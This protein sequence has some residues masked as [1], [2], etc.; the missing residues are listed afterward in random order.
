VGLG[1]ADRWGYQPF[2]LPRQ[3]R[4][5]GDQAGAA[6]NWRPELYAVPRAEIGAALERRVSALQDDYPGVGPEKR[7]R[8]WRVIIP[9]DLRLGHDAHFIQSTRQFLHYLE[10]PPTRSQS[11]RAN[12]LAKYYVCTAGVA[13]ARH[14]G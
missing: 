8:E 9:D 5:V 7:S 14:A 6:E 13:L 1:S 12:M 2:S 11:E 4:R 10:H 3:P